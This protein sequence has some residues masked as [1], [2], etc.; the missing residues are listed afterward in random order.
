MNPPNFFSTFFVFSSSGTV[1]SDYHAC[2]A[3]VFPEF[4]GTTILTLAEDTVEITEVVETTMVTNLRDRVGTV[5]EQSAGMTQTQVD[6]IVA[7]VTTG[8][9]FEE[10]AEGRVAHTGDVGNGRET[11]L[12]AEMGIDVT[13][14]LLNTSAVAWQCYLRKTRRR[15]RSRPFTP[16][17]LVEDGH[18]LHEGIEAI[19]YAAESVEFAIHLHDGIEREA[20]A[21]LGFYHHL[22]HRIEGVAVE[23]AIGGEVDIKLYGDL[24]DIVALTVALFPDMLEVGAGDEH[25][26]EVADHFTGIAD[27]TAHASGV[28]DEVQLVDLVI[29]Y[30]ISELLLMPV[31]NIKD[32]L[33]HQGRDFMDN[34]LH[35]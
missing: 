8:V 22:L 31:G 15:E 12:F 26:V 33:T 10:P 30:R 24:A 23:D 9:E 25:K 7:E 17:E 21:L 32:V 34:L 28:L 20:E 3:V 13:F 27:D 11:D 6:D 35:L 2:F 14:H 1:L 18:K 19:F 16:G 4:R 29:M 5:N